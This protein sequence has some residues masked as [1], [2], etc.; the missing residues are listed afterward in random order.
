M[1][2]KLCFK[3]NAVI[4]VRTSNTSLIHGLLAPSAVVG[5]D[6]PR[7]PFSKL[8]GRVGLSA[9]PDEVLSTWS[10]RTTTQSL[11]SPLCFVFP[12]FLAHVW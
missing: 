11:C 2:T 8:D 4:T 5:V 6:P 1:Y 9:T 10:V 12:G 3:S 7:G